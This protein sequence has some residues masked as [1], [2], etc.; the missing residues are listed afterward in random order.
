[1]ILRALWAHKFL[2]DAHQLWAGSSSLL[3]HEETE[4]QGEINLGS[5]QNQMLTDISLR[6]RKDWAIQ[7]QLCP[8]VAQPDLISI[9][10][11]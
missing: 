1:M 4:A 6:G 8:L 11:R 2:K 10:Q 9:A 5:W 3:L 7:G